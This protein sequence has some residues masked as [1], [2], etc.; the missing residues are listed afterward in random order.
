MISHPLYSN[1]F[2]A[3]KKRQLNQHITLLELEHA[4]GSAV[5]SLYG[6]QVLQWQPANQQP[7]FWLSDKANYTQG[8][9]IRGGVPICWPWF[10][11]YHN[12]SGELLEA[13][14]NH[15]FARQ[16]TWQISSYQIERDRFS[17][18]LNLSGE[19]DC[20]AWP[21]KYQLQQ[22]LVFA[23]TFQQKLIMTNLSN[24]VIHYSGALHSYLA[25]SH[26]ENVSVDTLSSVLFDD[27]LATGRQAVQTLV[28]CK[29]PIDRIYHTSNTQAL[30][31]NEW[32]R[33]LILNSTDCQQWVLWNPGQKIAS[34]V[35]DIHPQ[36]ENEYV[37]L[38]A[39]NTNKISIAP[40]QSK[41]MRQSI[42]IE[43]FL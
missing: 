38:E 9:A 40:M 5:I 24:Q 27:K 29:G 18:T 14:G 16:R 26:P 11:A 39:A 30:V 36:G 6:G 8:K 21:A 35:A 3:I 15:G 20:T 10:G 25:V 13:E 17:I 7:V 28:H 41:I 2:G 19:N 22:E 34:K 23:K 37:C 32:Q 1:A 43:N 4:L 42:A 12:E 33:K 31:D